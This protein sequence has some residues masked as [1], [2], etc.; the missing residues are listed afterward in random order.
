MRLEL[1]EALERLNKAG[2][3]C[4]NV[5]QSALVENLD[6]VLMELFG[7][8]N[9]SMKTE[10]LPPRTVCW[11]LDDGMHDVYIICEY[12]IDADILQV[13]LNYGDF[14]DT[15][16]DLTKHITFDK[17]GNTQIDNELNDWSDKILDEWT[18]AF[19]Y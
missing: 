12:Q 16:K 18:D 15:F 8:E 4:E 3:I 2:L 10:E 19:G 5:T 9:A 6:S 11:V 14:S 7:M 13:K 1:N 17:N